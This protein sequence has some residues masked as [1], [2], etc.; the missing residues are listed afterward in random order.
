MNFLK[1]FRVLSLF[2]FAMPL[3]AM[4]D[5]VTVTVTNPYDV[6]R[7]ELIEVELKD[8]YSKLGIRNGESFIVKNALGQ[9]VAYQ[10]SYDGKLLIDASVRP[11]GS[12][13]FTITP[14]TPKEMKTI[15]CGKQYPER[16]DDI[17]WENDRTAYRAYGPALQRTG[18]KAF[19]IDVWVKNT[20]DLEVDKRYVTE[21]SNHA[22]IEELKKQERQKK[23]MKWKRQ[24]HITLTMDTDLT[25]IRL[26]RRWV[27]ALLRFCLEGRWSY[28]I[29]IRHIKYW[30]M[31]LCAL[32]SSLII[33][34]FL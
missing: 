6:Q 16:V 32:Q 28:L 21:L 11:A 8:V 1:N 33:T 15:V 19:G 25:A 24:Q 10:I 22:K 23:L 2:M 4:A 9:Q 31:D 26:V 34:H 29:V 27:V 13:D 14:G 17:A 12:A 20:P 3:S 18:E 5:N 30:I 7:Q